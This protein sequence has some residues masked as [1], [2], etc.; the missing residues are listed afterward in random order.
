MTVE[1]YQ[2][3]C[4]VDE[5]LRDYQQEAKEAILPIQP[6]WTYYFEKHFVKS[7]Y[8]I[9]VSREIYLKIIAYQKKHY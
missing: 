7:H 5:R 8:H 2:D 1:R 9:F 4:L 6:H 3:I